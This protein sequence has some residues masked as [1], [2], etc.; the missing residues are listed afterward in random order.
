[1]PVFLTVR[2]FDDGSLECQ[3]HPNRHAVYAL[4]VSVPRTVYNHLM[5]N[6]K[7]VG[8]QIVKKALLDGQVVHFRGKIGESTRCRRRATSYRQSCSHT[9]FLIDTSIVCSMN[10][11]L[12]Q[13]SLGK[14]LAFLKSH[15]EAT[16]QHQFRHW[17]Q[18]WPIL[19]GSQLCVSETAMHQPRC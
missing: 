19:S 9:G 16:K 8:L 4:T 3:L 5:A 11:L 14:V 15:A 2:D 12:F 6:T 1:M 7:L 17:V 18:L 10:P 13:G